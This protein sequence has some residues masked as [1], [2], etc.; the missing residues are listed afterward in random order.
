MR[1]VTASVRA[2]LATALLAACSNA[3]QDRIL[4]V[5]ATGLVT[6][7]VYF[8]ANGTKA[9][10]PT[11]GDNVLAA[12]GIRLLAKGTSDTVAR[13]TTASTGVFK[14][15]NLPVGSYTLVVDT[16]TFGD[17]I[18]VAKIDSASFT[19]LPA[20]SLIVNVAISYPHLSIRAARS[21]TLT[22]GHRVFV[23]GVALN[24]AATFADSTADLTD[25]SGFIRLTRVRGNFSAGDSMRVLA[26]SGQR[27]SQPSLDNPTVFA[28]GPGSLPTAATLT[29]ALAAGADSGRRDAQLVHVPAA[30]ISDTAR[31]TNTFLLTVTDS[32]GPLQVELDKT[33]DPAFQSGNL[34]GNFVPG[35]TFDLLGVLMATGPGV[36]QLRPRSSADLTLIPLPVISIAAAR[37]LPPGRTVVVVGVALNN[38]NTFSDTTVHLE[39]NTGAIR[40]TRL[41]SSVSAQDSIKVKAVTAVR[42]L[43]PT[44]DAG[45]TT[46]LGIGLFPAAVSLT[47]AAAATAVGGARDAQLAQVL[48]ATVSDTAT[49]LGGFQLTVSDGSGNLAVL[50]DSRSFTGLP[51]QYIPNNRFNIVGVLVPTGAGTW[52]LKPRSAADLTK[53]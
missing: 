51:G 41:R 10:E 23:T 47:T 14:V 9:Y 33:A 15:A 2:L 24:A 20:E 6:G 29:T 36:W 28:L 52:T 21:P 50:L 45:T 11:G 48:N 43:E 40:L 7:L 1:H 38:L 12:V 35:N 13:A 49:V 42:A 19:V 4:T 46:P 37:L 16:T 27:G 44:L 26:T 17:S 18:Q 53:L 22:P 39:D 30:T 3:G 5:K 34:P 8:D 32:S 25:T 31:T